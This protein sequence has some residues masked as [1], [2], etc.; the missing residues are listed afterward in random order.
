VVLAVVV[1]VY[2]AL[3]GIAA[4]VGTL[5]PDEKIRADAQTRRCWSDCSGTAGAPSAEPGRD[6]QCR[7]PL[8]GL[9]HGSPVMLCSP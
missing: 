1:G 3:I 6:S 9:L 8:P 4:V 5:H 2:V 7:L